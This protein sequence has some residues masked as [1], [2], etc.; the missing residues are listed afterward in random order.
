MYLR[1]QKLYSNTFQSRVRSHTPTRNP[2]ASTRSV[3]PK[4]WLKCTPTVDSIS[5]SLILKS[6]WRSRRLTVA[7]GRYRF[8]DVFVFVVVVVDE[9]SLVP[10]SWKKMCRRPFSSSSRWCCYHY[11]LNIIKK[12]PQRDSSSIASLNLL[13]SLL[14]CVVYYIEWWWWWFK[15]RHLAGKTFF[16]CFFIFQSVLLVMED[17]TL[18]III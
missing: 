12:I 13:L 10:F 6:V 14:L 16:F 5:T 3:T 9:L 7:F 11:I 4:W 2:N 17:T 15:N 18:H 1:C 8:S